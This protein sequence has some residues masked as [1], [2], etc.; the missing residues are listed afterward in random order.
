MHVVMKLV[1]KQL[2]PILRDMIGLLVAVVC[3]LLESSLHGLHM[4]K[5]GRMPRDIHSV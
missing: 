5:S 3:S 2:P 4:H 1:E